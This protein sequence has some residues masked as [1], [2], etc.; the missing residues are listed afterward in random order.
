MASGPL[1]EDLSPYFDFNGLVKI[2]KIM[3]LSLATG[4]IHLEE[5]V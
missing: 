4:S 3:S 1:T 5:P 2:A